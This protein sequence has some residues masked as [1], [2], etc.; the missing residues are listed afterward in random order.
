M[1][2]LLKPVD[3]DFDF[4]AARSYGW[5]GGNIECHTE[6]YKPELNSSDIV[7]IGVPEERN[8]I[9]NE[10]TKF[11]PDEIRKALYR[12]FPGD[13]DKNIIDLGNLLTNDDPAETYNRLIELLNDIYIYNVSV[14]IL[15]G[16]Q[17]ITYPIAKSMDANNK[18]YNLSVIDAKIDSALIDEQMDNENYLTNILSNDLSKLQIMSIFGVQTYYN[19]PAKY[20]I[21]DKLYVDYYKLGEISKD[22]LSVEPELR[23]AHIV[24]IDT[25]VIRNS[26]MPAQKTSHPNGLTGQEIC[27]MTRLSGISVKNK[28]LGIFEY[29]PFFDKNKTGANLIAQ[30]IWYYVE[31][32]NQ[33]LPDYPYIDKNELLKFYVDNEMVKLNFYKNQK[34]G[35]WWVELPELVNTNKLFP[36]A[37]IDY[38]AAVNHKITGRIY[39]IINKMTI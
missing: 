24:S 4:S 31:G 18:N 34:T 23:E 28:I 12:L 21:F 13:W 2:H 32:K 17:D 6:A 39:Q 19:H 35:R 1:Y 26:D 8:A 36:C 3:L 16:S 9:D 11:A 33:M 37:E 30:M 22:V 7:I 14:I 15:G 29:N 20:E 27:T 10:G 5:L 38:K 25:G